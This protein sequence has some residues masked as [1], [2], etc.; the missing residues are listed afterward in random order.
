VQI[1]QL[2]R[3]NDL[4]SNVKNRISNKNNDIKPKKDFKG[5]DDVINLSISQVLY[6][7]MLS[8]FPGGTVRYNVLQSV[9]SYLS[10]KKKISASSFYNSLKK[11][12][13]MGLVEINANKSEK[14]A[15]VQTTS[16]TGE[17]LQ[18][19][20][21]L[22]S[23]S[24][25]NFNEIF[26]DFETRIVDHLELDERF[27]SVLVISQDI[28]MDVHLYP[29]IEQYTKHL[30]AVASEESYNRYIFPYSSQVHLT[31]IFDKRIREP[32]DEF[33]GCL[34]TTYQR[35]EKFF[36]LTP[37]ELIKDAIRVTKPSGLIVAFSFNIPNKVGHFIIDQFIN[38]LNLNPSVVS[39]T[40]D[41]L[42]ADLTNAGLKNI[43]VSNLNGFIL[44]FGYVP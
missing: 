16:K 20:G 26:Q 38:M 1:D 31:K 42:R 6:L 11:L 23:I 30:Y 44:G 34:L 39:I 21:S 33:D 24:G 35:E 9:N 19:I 32:N 43:S 3:R 8:S 4:N 29:F 40:E 22:I 18:Q 10:P 25:F 7:I 36:D 14:V 27:N 13:K 41:E 5:F 17:T 28:I 15:L 12:E 37:L 2:W